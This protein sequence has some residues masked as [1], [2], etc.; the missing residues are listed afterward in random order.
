MLRHT[1]ACFLL[2]FLSF[3]VSD[4]STRPDPQGP[5]SPE[6][7][8]ASW[9]QHQAM[10]KDSPFQGLPWR[11][12][13]PLQM[14]GRLVDI[15]VVPGAPYSFYVAFASGGLWKTDNNGVTF[16]PLFDEQPSMIMGDI[17]LDPSNPSTIWVG[18]GENNSS[19]SSYGGLGLFR[20][21]DAGKTWEAAG[22]AGTDRIGRILVD[23]RDGNRVY[24]AA[25]GKLYS[26]GGQ[27][28]VYR[29]TNGGKTWNLVLPGGEW[30]GFV[31][32]VMHPSDPD[33]LYAASWERMRR[34]WNFVEGGT[35]SGIYKSTDGGDHW[36][37]LEGGFPQGEHVGRIGL[38]IAPSAPDTVY[39]FLDNQELLPEAMWDMGDG[40]VT[41]KRLRTMTREQFL[42][43]DPEEIE[44]FLRSNDLDPALDAEGLLSM[45][46]DGDLDLETIRNALD[47]ANSNLFNSDLK[48]AEVYRSNDGGKSWR[49]T[50]D[51]PILKMVHTYGYYFGQIRVSTESPD[52]IYILG[53]PLLTSD[54]GGKSWRNINEP[55]VHG[56][57]QSF[58][59]DPAFPDRILDGNDGG[60]NMSYDGGKSWLKL[61]P[62][63]VGQF[64]TVAVD[65]ADPYNVYGGLQDNGVWKGS[66]RTDLRSGSDWTRIGGGDGMYVQVDFRDN[67]TTYLGFQFGNYRRIGKAGGIRVKPRNGIRE[68]ALRYNWNSPIALSSHNQDILYF[69][70][71]RL[72]RSMD[73]GETFQAISPDLTRSPERGDVP[74][75]TI[76]SISEST[77][78]FG[79]LWAGTD[80]GQ[81]WVSV[82]GGSEWSDVAATLPR[83]RWVSRVEAS[84]HEEKRAYVSLNGYRNDD[85]TAYVYSTEDLGRTWTSIADGLPAEPVNVIREDPVNPEVLYAGTDRGVYASMDRGKTWESLSGGIPH[86]PVHDLVIHPR[87]RELV[88]GTHGRSVW[89]LDVLPVQEMNQEIRESAAHLF[90]LE[91]VQAARSWK[92]RRDPWWHRPEYEPSITIPFWAREG[93]T[94]ELAIL[95]GDGRE[96]W[97]R[98]LQAVAGMNQAEWDLLLDEKAALKAEKKRIEQTKDV[99]TG[100]E[101]APWAEAVRLLRPLYITPG[102]YSVRVTVGKKT[103][104]AE[105]EITEPEARE[106]RVKPEPKIRG[107]K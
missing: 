100:P 103:A 74:F 43:T 60:L 83:D 44:D 54:D 92:S 63:A 28:G 38:A 25:L 33:T 93:G 102:N 87:E 37:R 41:P 55:N 57:H 90:P 4:A 85:L 15:E 1:L 7:G 42:A 30:T 29:T 80:D 52:R 39:A 8:Q 45:V 106:P 32:M 22:L 59:I 35:G 107:R 18:T 13:G 88:A 48:G 105:L 49:L 67:S 76:A 79:L 68:P 10:A 91:P 72:F 3:G 53:V 95:D 70:S 101:A 9:Q 2:T 71:N 16:Q 14:G 5:S 61:N 27:R 64:Y 47:D 6:Q 50:H 78:K 46:R 66:S 104:T 89:V 77:L 21:Q 58:W 36:T 75:A 51:R 99:E 62:V 34:P 11:C 82:D 65:M 69:G 84:R 97:S 94:V 98:E 17:A 24:V 81:V 56:D 40:A 73:Q 12:I 31:D 96:L 23:P 86:V 26:P 19:R 20:S